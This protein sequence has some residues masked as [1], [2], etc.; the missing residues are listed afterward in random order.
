[1]EAVI[2]PSTGLPLPADS[3]QRVLFVCPNV[4]VYQI[5]PLTSNKGYNASNWTDPQRPTAQQ[6][7]TARLRVLE[8]AIPTPSSNKNK[9]ASE[10][11]AIGET[12]KT[13]I[14]L[15]DPDSGALFA[16]A[17]YASPAVVEQALD[18][19]RFFA[20]TVRGEGGRKAVLGIGFEERSEAFD[21]GVC[22]QEVRKV[23]DRDASQAG[24]TGGLSQNKKGG[25]SNSKAAFGAEKKDFALKEG[26]TITVNLGGGQKSRSPRPPPTYAQSQAASPSGAGAT[27]PFLPPPPSARDVKA[28][29]RRSKRMDDSDPVS[30]EASATDMGFD[31]GEFGE[32]Q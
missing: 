1:M 3:I 31:D 10:D 13:D 17:P 14:L 18:S 5:P 25:P 26:Q 15:E 9:G 29:R 7:F 4:H 16:A 19:T 27:M 11:A 2:D 12:V 23:Q 28:E 24:G 32:F 6:I 22:L 20:I 8:T 21:F 30:G